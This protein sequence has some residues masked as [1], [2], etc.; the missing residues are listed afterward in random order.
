MPL[1]HWQYSL[2]DKLG[3]AGPATP[4]SIRGPGC[5]GSLLLRT[6]IN[7]IQHIINALATARLGVKALSTPPVSP[8]SWLLPEHATDDDWRNDAIGRACPLCHVNNEMSAD[9]YHILCECTHENV[10]TAREE[11]QIKIKIFLVNLVES[12]YKAQSASGQGAPLL[13][14][15]RAARNNLI[16]TIENIVWAS[17]MGNFLLFRCCL[18]LPYP[19]DCV[20]VADRDDNPVWYLGQLFDSICVRNRD[21]RNVANLWVKWGGLEYLKITNVWTSAVNAMP[22]V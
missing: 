15:T 8:V 21:L 2:G 9:S 13:D 16:R 18:V 6:S 7:G 5:S 14:I 17:E 20:S 4:L 12:C 1:C 11:L 22:M 10:V 3:I 19:A